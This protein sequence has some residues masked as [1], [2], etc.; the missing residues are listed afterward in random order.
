MP[1]QRSTLATIRKLRPAKV[2]NAVRRRW[3][4][5]RLSRLPLLE[6]AGL[7]ELGGAY[8]GWIVPGDLIQP[9]WVCY[10]VGAGGDVGFDLEL[11]RRYGIAVR[12]FDAVPGYVDDALEQAAGE[13]LFSAYHAAI[14]AADGPLRM[15]VTHD[16]QSRSLSAAGSYESSVWVEQPGRTLA[17]LMDQLGDERIDLLKLD[18]EGAE[19][20]LLPMLALRDMGVK[21][22]ACQL[23]HTGSVREALALIARLRDQGYEPVAM[24]SSVKIA[25]A[26]RDLL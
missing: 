24:R 3:F 20:E 21:L 2:R 25:F 17:S 18:I 10:S 26:D 7:V 9:S 23:H 12:A 15:Q 5:R 14:A 11:I 4:N 19:Y 16:P 22:F 8:G 1:G 13:P 6:A